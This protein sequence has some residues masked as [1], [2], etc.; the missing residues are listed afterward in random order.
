[1]WLDGLGQLKNPVT[2]N[3]KKNKQT[4]WPLVCKR[5]MLTERQP[6]VGEINANF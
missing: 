1:V 6:L 4:P 2:S 5:T 3:K